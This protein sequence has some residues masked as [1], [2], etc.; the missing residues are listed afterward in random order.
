M[1]ENSMPRKTET[2]KSYLSAL[3]TYINIKTN[4]SEN[5]FQALELITIHE[6]WRR[7]GADFVNLNLIQDGGRTLK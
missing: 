2:H 4:T 5:V 6:K 3:D 7:H 1:S